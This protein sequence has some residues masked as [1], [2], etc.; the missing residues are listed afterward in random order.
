L[1]IIPNRRSRAGRVGL[2][3]SG[4]FINQL[5]ATVPVLAVL[6]GVSLTAIGVRPVVSAIS[7]DMISGLTG[8]REYWLPTSRPI[9]L[10][11]FV[12]R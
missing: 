11:T 5:E 10:G 7:E 9:L 6:V 8:T 1:V 2:V 4:K 3:P 12:T